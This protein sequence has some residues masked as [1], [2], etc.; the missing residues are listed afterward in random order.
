MDPEQIL[1]SLPPWAQRGIMSFQ[2]YTRGTNWYRMA[3]MFLPAIIRGDLASMT[4]YLPFMFG[5]FLGRTVKQWAELFNLKE[6]IWCNNK[7]G[8]EVYISWTYKMM[9]ELVLVIVFLGVCKYFNTDTRFLGNFF[10]SSFM[11]PLIK[12]CLPHKCRGP[13]RKGFRLWDTTWGE[14]VVHIFIFLGLSISWKVQGMDQLFLGFLFLLAIPQMQERF[15]LKLDQ[16]GYIICGILVLCLPFS[17]LG[18]C[19]RFFPSYLEYFPKPYL[20]TL[21]MLANATPRVK[22]YYSVLGVSPD[23]DAKTIKRVF[24]E[25]SITLHPDKVGDDPILLEK[26]HAIREASDALTK[27]RAAY[28]AAIEN[29][30][31]NEMAPRCEAFMIMMYFWLLHALI[32]YVQID[33]NI[34]NTKKELRK[35]ILAGRNLD[36]RALGLLADEQLAAMKEW[37]Q[38]DTAELPSLQLNG[39]SPHGSKDDILALREVLQQEKIEIDPYPQVEGPIEGLQQQLCIKPIENGAALSA[40]D[41]AYEGWTATV[42][43]I[44]IATNKFERATTTVVRY[45]AQWEQRVVTLWPELPWEPEMGTS[46]ITLSPPSGSAG[47]KLVASVSFHVY[48]ARLQVI[49]LGE[50]KENKAFNWKLADDVSAYQNYK[51]EVWGGDTLLG[52]QRVHHYLPEHRTVI[53]RGPL[54]VTGEGRP[55]EGAGHEYRLFPDQL[56][57]PQETHS[58]LQLL[59]LE[60]KAKKAGGKVKA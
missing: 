14:V 37:L 45:E 2:Y 11:V 1:A 56:I 52:F 8:R 55:A 44:D 31:L 9:R 29:Q 24:R 3:F 7:V 25:L 18:I 13:L 58:P 12:I 53:L 40:E 54:V 42:E 32:D 49:K 5:Y 47:E 27:G 48:Y 43:G 21:C 41:G 35:Y 59:L 6:N 34:A 4:L 20:A 38:K 46:K 19:S 51:F 15:W 33:D 22:D 39:I 36:F 30:E 28:D 16:Q 57:F 10:L 23:S 26:F 50:E 17:S 60:N